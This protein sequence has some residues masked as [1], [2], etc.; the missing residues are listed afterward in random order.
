MGGGE[1]PDA[2][3]QPASGAMNEQTA[4]WYE[5]HTRG[6]LRKFQHA[7]GN[8]YLYSPASTGTASGTATRSQSEVTVPPI[9]SP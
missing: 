9:D 4:D 1:M 6:Q 8:R 3:Q 2:I 5:A 7:D